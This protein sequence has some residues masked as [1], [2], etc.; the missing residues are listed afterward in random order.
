MQKMN[1]LY[2]EID[3]K[4]CVATQELCE[5]LGIARKTLS[6]W[7]SKGCPK[8]SRGWWPIWELLKWKG[9][10]GNG[11]KSE[12]E[13]EEISLAVKKLK[14]EAEYKKQKAEEAAFENAIA[15]GEYIRKEEITAE[16]QRFFVVLKRSMFGYSRK[17][18]NEVGSFVDPVVARRIEKMVTEL[19]MDALGQLSIDGLYTAKKKKAQV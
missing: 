15:K 4:L 12:D 13:V 16:L 19:T 2:K 3:G 18:A 17:V 1:E 6:E 10:I 7:E 5:R 14:Y 9:L 8:A 11:V